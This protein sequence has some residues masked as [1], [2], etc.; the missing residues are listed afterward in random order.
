MRP[1]LSA[2]IVALAMAGVF[3]H[4]P[5]S[6]D[7]NTSMGRRRKTLGFGPELPHAVFKTE[8]QVPAFVTPAFTPEN[9]YVAAELF[10]RNVLKKDNVRFDDRASDYVLRGDSY[11]DKRIGVTH[12]YFRQ[13]IN[14]I[15]VVDANI[16]VNVKDG[17]VISYGDSVRL[18]Q[19]LSLTTHMTYSYAYLP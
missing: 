18:T 17:K 15:E 4:A 5:A 2:S 8:K 11:H 14:G 13:Y 3:A 7:S 10:V 6:G 19:S 1:V 9:P 16:N 12:A